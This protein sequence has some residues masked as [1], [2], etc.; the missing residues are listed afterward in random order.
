[1]ALTRTM[2]W[3][4]HRVQC[5][6]PTSISIKSSR[7]SN[8]VVLPCSYVCVDLLSHSNKI[9]LANVNCDENYENKESNVSVPLVQCAQR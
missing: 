4:E 9:V 5:M 6:V 3:K 7:V 8:F 2:K 1:M